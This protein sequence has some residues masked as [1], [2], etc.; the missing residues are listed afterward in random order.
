MGDLGVLLGVFALVD[1]GVPL[2]VCAVFE[3]RLATVFNGVGFALVA[4]AFLTIVRIRDARR[5][6]IREEWFVS[7][8]CFD[9]LTIRVHWQAPS[10]YRGGRSA[11]AK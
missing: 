1:L 11:S 8:L 2:G 10:S 7:C 3:A 9:A 4:F 6:R 5:R